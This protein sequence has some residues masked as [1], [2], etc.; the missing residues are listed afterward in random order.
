MI[1]LNQFHQILSSLLVTLRVKKVVL[2]EANKPEMMNT[3]TLVQN[4]TLAKNKEDNH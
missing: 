4:T 2:K 3:F 1:L